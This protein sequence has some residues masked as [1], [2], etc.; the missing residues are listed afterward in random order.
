MENMSD[1]RYLEVDVPEGFEPMTQ[2]TKSQNR[3]RNDRIQILPVEQRDLVEV[4]KLIYDAFPPVF[5]DEIE[6]VSK[7]PPLAGR[8]KLL[9]KHLSPVLQT[10]GYHVIKAVDADTQNI[11]GTAV[12]M[13]NGQHSGFPTSFGGLPEV[14]FPTH[15][16]PTTLRDDLIGPLAWDRK[17]KWSQGEVKEMYAHHTPAWTEEL[18]GY[19]IGRVKEMGDRPHWYLAP[20][21]VKKE[22]RA[23]GVGKALMSYGL[24]KA[25]MADPPLHCV[26][27]TLPNVRPVYYHLGFVPT[28]EHGTYKDT[29]LVRPPKGHLGKF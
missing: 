6:D 14:T 5:W 27:E 2:P 4:A 12:W 25:D 7:R 28:A 16:V 8:C 17:M 19:D 1:L 26:L 23:M 11:M 29:Q 20:L 18:R 21:C 10:A 13:E 9:A 22:Y 3:L 24:D 15:F